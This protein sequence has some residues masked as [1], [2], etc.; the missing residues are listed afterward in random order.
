MAD[1]ISALVTAVW[2]V[3]DAKLTEET[4]VLD[5]A[6]A[7][8]TAIA[9]AK[10]KL[11]GTAAIPADDNDIDEIAR[12]WIAD[13]AVLNLIPT[14]I[15]YYMT[16]QRLS[17]S[18]DDMTVSYYDKIAALQDLRNQLEADCRNGLDDAK[19]AINASDAPESVKAYPKVSTD[20]LLLNP[21]YR[22]YHRGPR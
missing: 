22:S 6:T 13:R 15:D 1:L 8:A 3:T 18:K 11:Y 16:K 17:D 5:Y 14:A 19:N 2:P 7:K 20:G 9:R 21:T 4:S 12:Y 10:R